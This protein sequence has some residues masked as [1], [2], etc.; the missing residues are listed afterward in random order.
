MFSYFLQKQKKIS[1]DFVTGNMNKPS[2]EGKQ[3][4]GTNNKPPPFNPVGDPTQCQE[5]S[6]FKSNLILICI[7]FYL[8][9]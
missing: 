6:D 8:K 1:V 5:K 4:K 7:I 9:F 3:K 2:K